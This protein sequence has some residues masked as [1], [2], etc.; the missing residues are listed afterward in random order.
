MKVFVGYGYNERDKWIESYI[1][2]L[3][4]AF[5]GEPITG[6]E[7]YG[8]HLEDGVR[9]QIADSDAVLAFTTRRKKLGNGKY[10][11]HQWVTDEIVA[12]IAAKRPFVEVRENCVDRQ[13]G[14][15][16]G[17][18]YITYEANARDKCLVEIAKALGQWK[19]Q[20]PVRLQLLPEGVTNAIRP[21]IGRAGFRCSYKIYQNGIESQPKETCVIRFK[22][23]LFVPVSGL[24][25]AASVQILVEAA[26]RTWASDYESVDAV[27]VMLRED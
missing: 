12:A 11:T 5:G 3:I 25:P 24:G 7:I 9:Q 10:S 13:P 22:G 4:R 19:Q 2:D 1:F 15:P 6:K 18:Q 16:G 21:S 17:R 14:M 8:Q 23:G 26:G 27:S 20:L